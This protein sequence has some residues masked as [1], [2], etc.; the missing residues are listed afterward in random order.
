MQKKT[1]TVKCTQ[2]SKVLSELEEMQREGSTGGK[3]VEKEAKI[4]ATIVCSDRENWSTLKFWSNLAEKH[5]K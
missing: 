2:V 5:K 3:Q 1:I 4:S